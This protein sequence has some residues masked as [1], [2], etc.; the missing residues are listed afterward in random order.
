[1]LAELFIIR[2]SSLPLGKP[3]QP[4]KQ[5]EQ[6][7]KNPEESGKGK[8]RSSKRRMALAMV[9]TPDA[10]KELFSGLWDQSTDLYQ[11]YQNLTTTKQEKTSGFSYHD[12]RPSSSCGIQGTQTSYIPVTASYIP[13]TCAPSTSYIPIARSTPSYVPAACPTPPSYIPPTS[14]SHA[15]P[16]GSS[17]CSDTSKTESMDSSSSFSGP[18]ITATVNDSINIALLLLHQSQKK[19]LSKEEEEKR[20]IRR[21]RNKIA[22]T[23]CRQKR[24][25]H[26]SNVGSEYNQVCAKQ[27]HLEEQ[28]GALQRE[29]EELKQLLETHYCH[30]PNTPGFSHD[31]PPSSFA[32]LFV[33]TEPETPSL[34]QELDPFN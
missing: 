7:K 16:C 19:K 23:K 11:A 25:A 2:P 13:V 21:E 24:R 1:V 22:A 15:S 27:K 32:D 20:R 31:L 28:I 9:S 33:K 14:I 5:P 34:K 18:P 26:S 6:Q 4:E 29:K 10:A 12:S 3:N 17:T 30:K 8:T